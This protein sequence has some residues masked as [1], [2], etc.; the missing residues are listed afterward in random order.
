MPNADVKV[1]LRRGGESCRLRGD[2]HRRSLKYWWQ[3]WSVPP[4]QRSR[5]PLIFIDGELACIVG[6]AVSATHFAPP[7]QAAQK[8]EYTL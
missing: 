8:I 5:I 2:S 1:R 4:W 6:Y 7:G 3:K